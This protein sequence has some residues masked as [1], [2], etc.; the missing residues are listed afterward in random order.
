[1]VGQGCPSRNY[2]EKYRK[3]DNWWKQNYCDSS[4][5]CERCAERPKNYGNKQLQ[6]ENEAF[7]KKQAKDSGGLLIG[8]AVVVIIIVCKMKGIF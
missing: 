1:M 7:R 3:A 8:I 6:R 2:C 4:T 5:G